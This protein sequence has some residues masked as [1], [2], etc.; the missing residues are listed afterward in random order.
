LGGA[1]WAAI[2]AFL[3]ARFHANE[4]LVT[5]MLTYVADLFVKYLV[6][7]PWRDP[8]ANNFP[9]TATFSDDAQFALFASF[10]WEWL[11]GTRLNTSVLLTVVAVP[12]AWLFMEKS[13]VG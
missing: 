9:I 3:R 2:A 4:I 5:L 7:G 12:L 11:A 10:G 8:G 13:F 6:Y 1:L